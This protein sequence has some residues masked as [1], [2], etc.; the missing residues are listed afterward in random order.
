[1]GGNTC[2]HPHKMADVNTGSFEL[3]AIFQ[4]MY[5]MSLRYACLQLNITMTYRGDTHIIADLYVFVA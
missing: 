1:M 3:C 5:I 2:Y 4:D